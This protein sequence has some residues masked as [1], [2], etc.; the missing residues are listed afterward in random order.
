ML[1]AVSRE[2]S[3]CILLTFRRGSGYCVGGNGARYDRFSSL[4]S[5]NLELL[6]RRHRRRRLTKK[7]RDFREYFSSD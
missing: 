5:G 4:V 1:S 6:N 3:T 7:P 2:S